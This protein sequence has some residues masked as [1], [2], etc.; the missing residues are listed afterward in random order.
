MTIIKTMSS[1]HRR[2]KKHTNTHTYIRTYTTQCP[3]QV[4]NVFMRPLIQGKNV[5]YK[6]HCTAQK[7]TI[8]CRFA[9]FRVGSDRK[10]DRLKSYLSTVNKRFI[11]YI[12]VCQ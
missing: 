1:N 9:A 5:R 4:I 7:Q 6:D 11:V 10:S 3:G 12:I 2:E 8:P